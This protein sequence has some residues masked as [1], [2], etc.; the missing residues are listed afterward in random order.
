MLKKPILASLTVALLAACST[1]QPA[2]R[3]EILW[4]RYGVPH[5]FAPDA[6]SLYHAFGWAQMRA[7]GNLVLRLYGEARGRAAEYWGA[8]NLDGDRWVRQMGVPARARQWYAALTPDERR[9]IDAFVAGVNQYARD[10]ADRIADEVEVVLPVEGADILAHSQRVFQF[11]F[12][13]GRAG[14]EGAADRWAKADGGSNAWAIG[15]KRSAS[16]RAMLV[17]NPHLP[18]S[19]FFTWFEAQ[20]TSPEVN[21]YGATLVGMPLLGIAFNDR[22][23]WTHTVNTLDGLDLYELTL[24]GGGYRY[25]GGVRPFDTEEQIIKI[26]NGN[27]ALGEEKLLVKR[28]LQGPIV[29]ERGGKALALRVA[30]LDL[31]HVVGQYWD[32]MR[33]TNLQEF[34]AAVGQL[35]NPLFTVMYADR[36]GRIMHLFGGRTPVRPAGDWKWAGI[37]PGDTSKTLWTSTHPYADLPRVVDPPS[38]WLQNANDP[39]WT[40]TFP[41]AIDPA[42]YP[43][44]MAP[45]GMSFRAQRSARMLDED[46]RITFD[47]LVQYKHSTRMELAD[48]LLDDL[49]PLARSKGGILA[50]AAGVLERWDRSAEA[51]SHGAVLFDR[52]WREL[53]DESATRSPFRTRWDERDPRTT[54]DGFADPLAATRALQA[55]ALRLTLERRALDVAWGELFRLRRDGVDL[56]ANGGPGDLG[57][58][59]VLNYRKDDDGRYAAAGGDSYVAVMEF[60][61]TVRA[62]SL[63]APGNATQ[64]G[65]PHRADQLRLFSDKRLKPVWRTRV[66]IE[67]NLE[68]KEQV[69]RE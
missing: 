31:P 52:F 53:L 6:E 48:R 58:F 18:W 22:L 54:P 45:R 57:I 4:D 2:A 8:D 30:S 37:V 64:P 44:H 28:S 46:D 34:E 43:A 41:P 67:G 38:G 26:K 14:I 60:G 17:A 16:G 59:R 40:T 19:V 66:E 55:A 35:Q 23:G 50:T 29:S 61:D 62:L 63:L 12:I 32:M 11:E 24:A 13:A 15:P 49:V 65:S 39:P 1:P 20:L 5:I 9:H 3:T 21:A 36:D 68:M 33:A 27:G 7:H 10:H 42:T 47:E 69:A 51:D 25:D 56:P